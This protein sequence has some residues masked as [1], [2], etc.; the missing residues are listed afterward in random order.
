M[1]KTKNCWVIPTD[2]A[3]R[4]LYNSTLKSFC[5]QK[6]ID[7]MFIN[8]GKVSGANF[9]GLEKALNNGFQPHNIYITSNEEI[10]VGDWFYVK[11]PNIYGGN[12]AAKCLGF[13]ENCWSEHILTDVA[14]EKGYHPSHCVKIILTTD[15]DLIKDGVQSIDDEFLEWFVKNSSCERV[16]IRYTVDF[17]SKAVIIIPKEEPK[18]VTLE[19]VAEEY[20]ISKS[21]SSVFQKAHIRDFIAGAKWQQERM[22]SDMQEYAEF[23]VK[24]D[25][26][27]M[28]L[29]TV[30][31]WYKQYKK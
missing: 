14:D 19:E 12:V 8:D 20:A 9:W 15:Q 16:E 18:Q 1:E 4:L 31:D 2:K 13:G 11:T 7:G 27:K 23:C 30:E 22:Y 3:S 29:L 10:K 28:P 21:S 25:R 5:I 26:N 6:E 17:N 24:C